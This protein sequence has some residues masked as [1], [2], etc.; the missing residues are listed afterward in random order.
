MADSS[1]A[2]ETIFYHRGE[3]NVTRPCEGREPGLI[4]GG[5]TNHNGDY[6]VMVA[7]GFV[8]PMASDRNR[9]VAPIFA[10]LV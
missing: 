7:P 4:P 2:T 3:M 9:V 5:G 6:S 10:S 8:E 1:S